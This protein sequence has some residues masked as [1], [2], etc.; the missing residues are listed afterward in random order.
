MKRILVLDGAIY[1]NLYHPTDHWTAHL[2]QVPFD[3]VHLPSGQAVPDLSGY[4]HMIITG[5]EGSIVEPADW[6]DVEARAVREG[7]E[8]GLPMLASCFGHQMLALAISGEQYAARAPEPEMGWLPVEILIPDPLLQDLPNPFHTF[9]FHFD[10]VRN[11]PEPWKV[12]AR[13]AGCDVQIMRYGEKP[14]WGIQAHPEIPPEE[15]KALCKG[16]MIRRP[17]RAAAIA[18]ALQTEPRDDQVVAAIVKRFL[19]A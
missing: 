3:S 9:N 11:P 19:E 5:S 15:A 7:L 16:V 4:T 2:G 14:I 8:R 18:P 12:L 6:Y 13:S 10:E 17:D 1:R